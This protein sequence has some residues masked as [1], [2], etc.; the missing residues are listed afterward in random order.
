MRLILII[1]LLSISAIAQHVGDYQEFVATPEFLEA[2]RLAGLGQ[3]D[4]ALTIFENIATQNPRTTLGARSLLAAIALRTSRANNDRLI[5]RLIT[6]FSGSRYEIIGKLV[7]TAAGFTDDDEA[8]IAAQDALAQSFG[9]PGLSSILNSEDRNTLVA[10][11]RALPFETRMGLAPVY[12]SNFGG[13]RGLGR[14]DDAISLARFN[15]DAYADVEETLEHSFRGDL[16]YALMVKQYGGGV[17]IEAQPSSD[18]VVVPTSPSPNQ[19]LTS[20]S[21]LDFS[22]NGG[23]FRQPGV[24]L[25]SLVVTLDGEP[26]TSLS[27]RFESGILAENEVY[28]RLLVSLTVP[29]LSPGQ[30][31]VTVK[32]SVRGYPGT[33]AGTTTAS[34]SFEIA[35]AQST[36][37]LP[38]TKDSTLRLRDQHLNEG[39]NP[40]LILE[41]IQGK[42]THALVGFDLS[43]QNLTGLTSA[44]LVLTVDPSD[45]PTGWGNGRNVLA[46]PISTGWLEGNGVDF[47]VPNAQ[48]TSGSGPGVTWFSPVDEDISNNYANSAVNWNGAGAASGP[49]TALPV[50]LHNHQAGEV[51]FDVTQDILSG[52]SSWLVRREDENVGSQVHFY[53]K[54]GGGASA[55]PR[56]VLHYGASAN[57]PA[58]DALL[59]RAWDTPVA[60]LRNLAGLGLSGGPMTNLLMSTLQARSSGLDVLSA[61]LR[62]LVARR[63]MALLL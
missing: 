63:E 47:G 6:E 20:L 14:V 18:P 25:N 27:F 42:T 1:L 8:R 17:S 16:R 55:G 19:V 54:E 46:A 62:S 57:K 30:H 49:Q 52:S 12:Y 28:E 51:S 61:G 39:A 29:D 40:R 9:G 43:Q 38:V 37:T 50:Q 23:D 58:K 44:S 48:K 36:Q 41:K 35:S 32:A 10:E 4:E 56:L 2:D 53:S 45:S 33:G 26:L 22:I 3:L 15:Q 59:A 5:N 11:L 31:Q 21:T 60:V 7:Q 24:D 34:W 13:L